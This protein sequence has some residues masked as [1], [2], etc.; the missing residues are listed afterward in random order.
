MKKKYHFCLFTTLVLMAFLLIMSGLRRRDE[1]LAAR[2]APEILR[3]HV[4]ANSDSPEDQALKLEVKDLLLAKIQ[5]GLKAE[6]TAAPGTAARASVAELSRDQV[7][8]YITD[9]KYA[10]EQDAMTYIENRGTSYPVDIL[11]ETCQFPEKTYGDMTFPAGT[12][13]AVRVLIGEGKGQNFWC[14]LYPSLCHLDSTHAIV[15]DSSKETLRSL[16]PEDDFQALLTARRGTWTA[17]RRQTA[18][19][20]ISLQTEK[21]GQESLLPRMTIRFKLAELLSAGTGRQ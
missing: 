16:L 21:A 1:A 13:D 19:D 14:V 11:F 7:L 4:L 6:L 8:Q 18:G 15:P 5:A 12:Y 10:L 17:G 3:F 2:I 20:S 9:H